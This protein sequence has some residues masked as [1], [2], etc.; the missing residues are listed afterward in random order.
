MQ[1]CPDEEANVKITIE[2]DG[3]EVA[4]QTVSSTGV[5]RTQQA[6][7]PG[8]P[9]AAQSGLDELYA[10][11]AAMGAIDAGPAPGGTA[12]AAG[13]AGPQVFVGAGSTAGAADYSGGAAP[14][15]FDAH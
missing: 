9:G 3:V 14:P 4:S 11:A 15:E 13:P 5:D 7:A 6:P 12:G 1:C 8:S 2:I 10:K